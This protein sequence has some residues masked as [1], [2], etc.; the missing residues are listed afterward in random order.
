MIVRKFGGTSVQF[1]SNMKQVL[2]II[3]A[4]SGNQF[5][6]LSACRGITDRLYKLGELACAGKNEE[7]SEIFCFISNHHLTI[8]NELIQIEEYKIEAINRFNELFSGLRNILEGISLLKELTPRTKSHIASFGEKFSSTILEIAA[9]SIG[10]N[11]ILIPAE[12]ILKVNIDNDIVEVNF[13]ET[14]I[15]TKNKIFSALEEGYIPI[16][17]GFVCSDSA[18]NTRV[19]T[20]GGSDYSAAVFGSVLS[21]DEVQIWTD[22]SGILSGDPRIFTDAVCISEMTFQQVAELSFYGAKVLHPD[23]IQPAVKKDIPVRVLNTYLPEHGGTKISHQNNYKTQ[24]V[25]SITYK[26]DLELITFDNITYNDLFEIR[27]GLFDEIKS[28]SIKVYYM[29][30]STTNLKIAFE[31]DT[32]FD[33]DYSFKKEI[34]SAVC[35]SGFFENSNFELLNKL[36]STFGNSLKCYQI[37]NNYSAVFLIDQSQVEEV[38]KNIHKLILETNSASESEKNDGQ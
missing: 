37:N 34:V 16:S 14:E 11:T 9:R 23:T 30:F 1:S 7:I 6:I 26:K 25:N 31:K 33:I 35:I 5:I 3:A 20:R 21:A 13:A 10:L 24:I 38:S 17:Q 36:L 22:V 19:L 12:D 4:Y 28:K 32:N 8:V 2:E 27:T 15:H 29:S 18:G